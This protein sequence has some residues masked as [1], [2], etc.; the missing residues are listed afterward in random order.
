MEKIPRASDHPWRPRRSTTGS[1]SS[2][3]PP[4]QCF[5]GQYMYQFMSNCRQ[6]H[7][8]SASARLLRSD[9]DEL[10]LLSQ[11]FLWFGCIYMMVGCWMWIV[12]PRQDQPRNIKVIHFP[13]TF[14]CITLMPMNGDRKHLPAAMK[15]H[16][17]LSKG[18]CRACG[19][20]YTCRHL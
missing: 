4:V 7:P 11:L 20:D 17:K 9:L 13:G 15:G 8:G 2:L 12:S 1:V 18:T 10:L 5:L 14:S 19:C 16:L 6:V 3:A